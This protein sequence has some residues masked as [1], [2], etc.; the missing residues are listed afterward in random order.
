MK[1]YLSISFWENSEADM[2]KERETP[3]L[4]QIHDF[5]AKS[6]VL[7]IVHLVHFENIT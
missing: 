6:Y 1:A 7:G 3:L 4:I 2:E 5:E